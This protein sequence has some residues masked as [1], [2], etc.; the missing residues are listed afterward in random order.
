M[1]WSTLVTLLFLVGLALCQEEQDICNPNPCGE[2]TRCYANGGIIGCECITGFMVPDGGDPFDGCF[3][4]H[5][6]S[7]SSPTPGISN[8]LPPGVR[9]QIVRE[10]QDQE[11][12]S[13]Q[14]EEPNNIRNQLDQGG[15]DTEQEKKVEQV[16]PVEVE[17]Q[18]D[19]GEEV[20]QVVEEDVQ[21]VEEDVQV[22]VEQGEQDNKDGGVKK[23]GSRLQEGRRPGQLAPRRP[24]A[25]SRPNFIDVDTK[26]L[27]P[28]ECLVHEDCEDTHFCHPKELKCHDACTLAVCGDGAV[29]GAR[30]HRPVCACPDGFEGNPYDTCT[31]TKSRVGMLFRRRK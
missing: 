9:G 18:Q 25:T 13:I 14:I 27:F 8:Q 21:V 31:K 7:G 23:G 10:S 28:D 30:L 24:A 26:D 12:R 19:Q 15:K 20:V 1:A 11:P 17:Q 22:V 16:E 4:P 5:P 2:N 29:C 6:V 3:P